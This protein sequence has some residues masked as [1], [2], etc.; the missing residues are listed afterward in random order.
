MHRRTFLA[1]TLAVVAAAPV[2]S[3]FAQSKPAAGA[4][5][6]VMVY[7]SATCG[8]CSKWME[9][10]RGAG[11]TVDH[12]DVSDA[13]LTAL[14]MQSGVTDNVASCHTAHVDGYTVVGHVPADDVKKMLKEKPKVLGIAVPGMPMGSPGMEQG[15]MKQ[16]YD[17]VTFVKGGKTAVYVSH[18]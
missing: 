16:P 14:S 17:T 8:C 5:P 6:A 2:T 18:R 9:H 11:F 13:Q 15:G 12:K 4:L 3:L 7:K 10:M 1:R